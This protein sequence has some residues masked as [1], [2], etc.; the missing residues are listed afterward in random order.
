MEGR[1]VPWVGFTVY[2]TCLRIIARL[3]AYCT[4]SPLYLDADEASRWLILPILYSGL[5]KYEEG[6]LPPS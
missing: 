1:G 6:V 5:M 4:S 3:T 2:C